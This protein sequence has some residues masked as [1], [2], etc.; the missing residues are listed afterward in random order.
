MWR[1]SE[2]IVLY[3]LQSV[4]TLQTTAMPSKFCHTLI[5]DLILEKS[6][7]QFSALSGTYTSSKTG[8]RQKTYLSQCWSACCITSC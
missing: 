8:W 3:R 7:M 2:N 4:Q 6:T 5:M 1:H